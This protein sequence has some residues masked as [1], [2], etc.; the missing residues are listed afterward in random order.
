MKTF[1]IAVLIASL[2]GLARPGGAAEAT[3]Q[4]L[5]YHGDAARSGNFI[6]PKLDAEHARALHPDPDFHAAIQGHVYAQPLF[7][8]PS[9]SGAGSLLV[10]TEDNIVYAL[11]GTSGKTLW[12][13]SLGTPVSHWALPC[14]NIDPLGITG[15]PVIDPRGAALYVDAMI[16]GA[17]GPTHAIFGLSLRDGSVLP[18]WPLDV[19][20][21]LRAQGV[22]FPARF[23]NERGALMILGD[24]LYVPFGGHFGDCGS[25][26]GSVL[27]V[28][29]DGDHAVRSWQTGAR[30]GG[31]W[32]PAGISSD[33]SAL[34]VATGNTMGTRQWSGGE[35]VIR[36]PPDLKFS[37]QPR[38][39]FAPEDWRA[40]DDRDAD[41][42]SVAPVPLDL[43]RAGGGAPLIVT[44][45]KDG[46]AYLL[47]RHNLGG[48]GGA[49]AATRVSPRAILTAI[50]FFP[51]GDAMGVAFEGAG[52]SCPAGGGGRG[53][54][55]LKIAGKPPAIATG[56]CGAVDGR[57]AP[58]V[59]TTDGHSNPV[60]WML[61]A[62]GDDRLYAFRGDDGAKLFVSQPMKGLRHF[63]TLIATQDRLYVAGDNAVYAFAF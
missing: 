25:Y 17:A 28:K 35:A 42:G 60:V 63:D 24:T 59:T 6:V 16:R 11:D 57:G 2:L 32:A 14:G 4:V 15:T 58:I 30:A 18:G 40:L 53:L 9:G 44:L 49:L 10:A 1:A 22:D 48:I 50:A 56:W 21:A 29:L 43:P 20:A 8:H 38:D 55:V 33:G 51:L 54:V 45:G 62:E 23:Q 46:N 47:D 26:H 3:S 12:Q 52:A 31:I 27:G 39:Y 36:L 13:R 37:N 41:L 7:W 61:G 5:T 34:Y 19:A